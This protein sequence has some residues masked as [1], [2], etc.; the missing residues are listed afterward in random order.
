MILVRIAAVFFTALAAFLAARHFITGEAM[1]IG[2]LWFSLSPG[3]L[4]LAQ[5]VIQRYLW[6][7]IWDPGII[8]ILQQ[9]V[10][11]LSALLALPFLI[12]WIRR[13]RRSENQEP[14]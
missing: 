13:L 5:A 14:S 2:G 4:N 1:L 6:P 3:T 10:W 8:W 12:L 7:Q 9:P 11:T